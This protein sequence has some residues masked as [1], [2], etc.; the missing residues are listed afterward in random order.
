MSKFFPSTPEELAALTA[1]AAPATAG[2]QGELVTTGPAKTP[3]PPVVKKGPTPVPPEMQGPQGELVTPSLP[4]PPPGPPTEIPIEMRGA[5]GELVTPKPPLGPETKIDPALLGPQGEL[6]TGMPKG[7]AEKKEAAFAKPQAAATPQGPQEAADVTNL[8][9]ARTG[10]QPADLENLLNAHGVTGE[11]KQS[12]FGKKL[13]AISKNTG[14]SIAEIL[15]AAMFGF[16]QINQPLQYQI[17]QAGEAEAAGKQADRD[18]EAKM[19]QINRDW[20]AAQYAARDQNELAREKARLDAQAQQAQLDR[21]SAE[22]IA[23]IRGGA[24]GAGG[25]AGANPWDKLFELYRGGGGKK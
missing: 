8:Q 21:A 7:A 5:Q 22:K 4:K 24:S 3:V 10:D 11:K 1:A 23:G 2:A 15:Q 16:G 17:R 20:Q 25:A 19:D 12:E 14:R 9:N 18:F 13:K 6:L